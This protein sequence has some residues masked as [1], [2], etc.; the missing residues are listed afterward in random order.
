MKMSECHGDGSINEMIRIMKWGIDEAGRGPLAGPVAVGIF[1]MRP[2][3]SM[4]GFPKGRDS[5]KMSEREREKWYKLFLEE[6]KKG[7]VDFKV[8]FGSVIEVDKKGIVSAIRSAMEKC[9]KTLEV[10]KNSLLL[11]D[12][13][14]LAPP[15]Y[16]FQ[17]TIIKGD[18]KE[19][20]I[21]CAS[22]VAK[23]SRDQLMKKLSKKYPDY[24]FEIHK[25]YGTSHHRD[26][27][28][29]LGC[30]VLHRKSFCKNIT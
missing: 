14:L 16:L 13:A 21:A 28:R 7:N 5:K 27:I 8:G 23:V 18:E 3:F 20:L 19:K 4:K 11:L 6:K 25:G 1:G 9:L 15:R 24:A 22:I 2:G 17:K 26:L 29:T 12:G 10:S 30:S